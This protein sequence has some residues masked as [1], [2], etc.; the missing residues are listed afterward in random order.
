MQAISISPIC[1]IKPG[2]WRCIDRNSKK[3]KRTITG[4]AKLD[5]VHVQGVLPTRCPFLII[6]SIGTPLGKKS[7]SISSILQVRKISKLTKKS[8]RDCGA[9][10]NAKGKQLIKHGDSKNIN[11]AAFNV[12]DCL[13]ASKMDIAAKNSF[14]YYMMDYFQFDSIKAD[15]FALCPIVPI[16]ELNRLTNDAIAVVFRLLSV[17][18]WVI[19]FN[20]TRVSELKW[21]CPDLN[22]SFDSMKI[23]FERHRLSSAFVLSEDI[24]CAHE[25]YRELQNTHRGAMDFNIRSNR[26]GISFLLHKN[27]LQIQQSLIPVNFRAHENRVLEMA[28][29]LNKHKMNITLL[30]GHLNMLISQVVQQVKPKESLIRYFS[31]CEERAACIQRNLGISCEVFRKKEVR[32]IITET[33]VVIDHVN[34]IQAS[35]LCRALSLIPVGTDIIFIGGDIEHT[36]YAVFSTIWKHWPSRRWTKKVDVVTSPPVLNRLY[37]TNVK[38]LRKQ[39]IAKIKDGEIIVV[40]DDNESAKA[41]VLS[42]LNMKMGF[43]EPGDTVILSNDRIKTIKEVYQ[44]HTVKGRVKELLGLNF[45]SNDP[46]EMS[47]NREGKVIFEHDPRTYSF[48]RDLSNMEHAI[49]LPISRVK[50]RYTHCLLYT[51]TLTSQLVKLGR[52]FA[53][54]IWTVSDIQTEET[55]AIKEPLVNSSL[56][57][58]IHRDT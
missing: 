47:L 45:V 20:E 48:R 27:I 19:L 29:I 24:K 8:L 15:Y 58:A 9:L 3:S 37:G 30:R 28:P 21:R 49:V 40:C 7:F 17:K 36:L 38:A 51:Q 18:P 31:S 26:V 39:I 43:F 25:L 41:F 11:I 53:D 35:V 12:E 57:R 13:Q 55:E 22:I 46:R 14:K 5:F 2:W 54:Q 23:W 52:D 33:V 32:G 1:E 56:S 4:D 16:A 50:G 42:Q 10:V 44:L 6:D 34:G